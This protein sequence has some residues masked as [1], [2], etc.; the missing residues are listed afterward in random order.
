MRP[1]IGRL[2]AVLAAVAA[3]AL[4]GVGQAAPPEPL[5]LD[6]AV[7]LMEKLGG[8]EQYPNANA[9]V[10]LD[11]TYIEFDP[12]GAY[13]EYDHALVKILTDQGLDEH[14]D[15]S[16]SYHRRYGAIEV[17]LAR[18]I[19]RDGSEI[20][21]TDDLITDGT[22]P[23]LAAMNIYETDFREKTIVFPNLEV[24]DAIESLVLQDYQPL[25][26][27]GFNGM[28]FFQSHEPI[29]EATVTIVGPADK[30]LKY[31][32]KGGD[33]QFVQTTAGGKNVYAWKATNVAQI[34]SEPGMASPAEFATRLIVSTMHTWQEMS[35][36]AWQMSNDKCVADESVK[37]LVADV[38]AGLTTTGDKIRAIHYWIIKNVRYLGISM[39]R[40]AFI[41]PH[42]ASYTLEK[43]YGVCRDK[44]VL[45]VTMLKEIGVPAWVVFINV[46]RRTDTEVPNL[47][48]EHGIV[49]IKGPDGNYRYIDPTVEESREVFANHAGDHEVLVATEEGDDIGMAPHSPASQNAG[50]IADASTLSADGKL[51]GAVNVTG[52]GIYELILRTIAKQAKEEQ[53]RMMWEQTIHRLNPG[54]KLTSFQISSSEDLDQPMAL[55]AG[56]E[57]ADYAV[58]AD[59][60]LVFRVP[61]ATGSFDFLSE[62]LFGRLTGLP[63]RKYPLAIGVTLGIQEDAMVAIPDGYEVENLPDDVN[64]HQGVINLT[65]HYEFVPPATSDARPVVRYTRTFGIESWE[66]SPKDYL[67]LKEA[68]RL[69]N[70]SARGE[71]ILKRREG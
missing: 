11:E 44:A 14:G 6:Q 58:N 1:M 33:V 53:I 25:L 4:P 39:D 64:L 24:G 5:K 21:V 40:G 69:A 28:Y 27:D 67:A 10:G 2:L 37:K 68:V 62:I 45:M 3:L 56:Y 59:P 65:M 36:Y 55:T 26:K 49:A 32:V 51:T 35:R 52:R 38:T 61:A 43:E 47:F 34:D 29:V 42:F 41:E 30:P 50:H 17:I 57:V 66:I 20:L 8:P 9:V 16:F 48:F 60:Y 22:P 19:K 63:E 31:V 13:K 18:V 23:E 54:A 46:S 12:T 70:R 15:L 71:V 7:R